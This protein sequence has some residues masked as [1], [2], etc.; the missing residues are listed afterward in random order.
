MFLYLSDLINLEQISNSDARQ[1]LMVAVC[2]VS[3]IVL[4][5]KQFQISLNNKLKYDKEKYF[6]DKT[7]LLIRKIMF[8]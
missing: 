2:F 7:E 5:V 3:Q 6:M 8:G 1:L 4:F